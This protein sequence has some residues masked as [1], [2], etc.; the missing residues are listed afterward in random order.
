MIKIQQ[1]TTLLTSIEQ[2]ISGKNNEFSEILA[3]VE[4]FKKDLEELGPLR[5]AFKLN[6]DKIKEKIEEKRAE[7]AKLFKL[8]ELSGDE[9]ARTIASIEEMLEAYKK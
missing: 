6:M 8:A 9:K 5:L 2:K 7:L 1:N 4:Q 3:K